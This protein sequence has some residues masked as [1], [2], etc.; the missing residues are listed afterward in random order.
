MVGSAAVPGTA[1]F[2]PPHAVTF[3]RIKDAMEVDLGTYYVEQIRRE[4]AEPAPGPN[5][6][7]TE[8]SPGFVG[9]VERLI[10]EAAGPGQPARFALSF[11][12][13]EGKTLSPREQQVAAAEH[14]TRAAYH[15]VFLAHGRRQIQ[16]GLREVYRMVVLPKAWDRSAWLLEL[17]RATGFPLYQGT[18]AIGANAAAELVSELVVTSFLPGVRIPNGT[19]WWEPVRAVETLATAQAALAKA[20]PSHSTHVIPGKAA[21]PAGFELARTDLLTDPY[22]PGM[23]SAVLRYTDGIDFFFVSQEAASTPA[24]G[25]E[26]TILFYSGSGVMQCRFEHGGVRYLVMGRNHQDSVRE[27]SKAIFATAIRQHP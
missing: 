17:D 3:Q 14:R 26:D 7:S 18:Y 2:A 6:S 22:T 13:R 1:S 4:R 12:G 11:V 23:S 10:F 8:A 25:N 21:V 9:T 15:L 19:T 20:L 16:Q 27:A 5:L 24:R